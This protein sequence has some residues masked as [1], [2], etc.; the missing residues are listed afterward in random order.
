MSAV[1]S[2]HSRLQVGPR[3]KLLQRML[4]R[5]WPATARLDLSAIFLQHKLTNLA[6]LAHFDILFCSVAEGPAFPDWRPL[7]G[8]RKPLLVVTGY[9]RLHLS[10]S[11]WL[12][13][14]LCSPS[15]LSLDSMI[16]YK[17]EANWDCPLSRNNFPQPNGY[18][19]HPVTALIPLTLNLP[20][21]LP[22]YKLQGCS[23]YPQACL[24]V[25][26]RL[27]PPIL[28]QFPHQF[29]IWDEHPSPVSCA[30]ES[31]LCCVTPVT[32]CEGRVA[33]PHSPNSHLYIPWCIFNCR[34]YRYVAVI[35]HSSQQ[36]LK[37][38][39]N[40]AI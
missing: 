40:F 13:L 2:Q 17:Y 11:D 38:G 25:E 24:P 22:N 37:G 36:Q 27:F 8:A 15:Q 30:P 23:Q 21:S 34:S 29:I 32:K 1:S 20:C 6:S 12:V 9:C 26:L 5:A 18:P 16:T 28:H 14:F 35:K 3:G 33:L 31:G 39:V 10:V 7:Q 19:P 4:I